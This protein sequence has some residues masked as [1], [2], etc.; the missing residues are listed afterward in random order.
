MRLCMANYSFRKD[1]QK[2]EVEGER[3]VQWRHFL[4]AVRGDDE[5]QGFGIADLHK[6]GSASIDAYMPE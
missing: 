6:N 1:H 3:S 2:S 5:F 4:S